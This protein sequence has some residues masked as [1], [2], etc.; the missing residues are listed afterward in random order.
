MHNG[1]KVV[2]SGPNQSVKSY[3]TYNKISW[4][5]PSAATRGLL[6]AL[7]S[8][9]TLATLRMTRKRSNAFKETNTKAKL[10]PEKVADIICLLSSNCCVAESVVRS[11]ISSKGADQEKT[12]KRR[13]K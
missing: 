10:N 11:H 6:S 7:F 2:K 1:E 13:I 12:Y 8:Q 9:E 5:A 3:K 4:K